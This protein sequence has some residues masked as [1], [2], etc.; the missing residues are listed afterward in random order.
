MN[1]REGSGREISK[2]NNFERRKIK[3][4]KLVDVQKTGANSSP[5]DTDS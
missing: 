1:I 2:K 3:E 5:T 4:R